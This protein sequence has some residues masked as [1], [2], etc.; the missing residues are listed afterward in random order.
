M[1]T[2]IYDDPVVAEVRKAKEVLSA[3]FGY[4]VT[5]ILGDVQ[6]RESLSGRKLV[7]FAPKKTKTKRLAA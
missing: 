2:K 1:K 5:A 7:S 4:D 3:K 6:K